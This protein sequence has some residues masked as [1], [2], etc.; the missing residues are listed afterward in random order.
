[1]LNIYDKQNSELILK[2]ITQRINDLPALPRVVTAAM[3]LISNPDTTIKQLEDLI[4]TDQALAIRVL[5]MAN[6][7]FYGFSR[8]IVSI[9]QAVKIL[10]FNTLRSLLVSSSTAR[11]FLEG[12]EGRDFHQRLW[13]HSLLTAVISR[14]VA[15]RGTLKFLA[16]EIFTAGLL[17]D[18]GK[19]IVWKHFPGMYERLE[20]LSEQKKVMPVLLETHALGFNHADVGALLAENWNLPPALVEA[21][22]FHHTPDKSEGYVKYIATVNLA[23]TL[24][25]LYL[26]GSLPGLRTLDG[27]LN[28]Y[29]AATADFPMTCDLVELNGE[30]EK[31]FGD[32]RANFEE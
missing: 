27:V 6:S 3:E 18:L 21:V 2:N 1:M 20:L 10:G 16:E 17:H 9:G 29:A 25:K 30:I 26:D 23:N 8:Q 32:E 22:R 13:D 7:A 11:L 15:T 19:K 31:A 12:E 4:R 5:K 28:S 14:L 24:A